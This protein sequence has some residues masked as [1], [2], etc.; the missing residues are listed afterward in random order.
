MAL[1][2]KAN[3]ENII[4]ANYEID[5]KILSPFLPKG[6][7]LDL[8][9]EKCYISLVGFMFKKTKLFT[10][11]I[12]F[13]GN[14]EEIN[15]RFYV[16]RKEENGSTKRGVVFINET[17]PYPIVAWT[18]NK[19]YNENYTVVPTKHKIIEEK[20]VKKV[21]F[22]WLLNKKWNSIAVTTATTSEKMKPNSLESFIYEHYYGYTKTSENETE[23]YK[24]QHPSWKVSEVLDYKIECDF[25]AMYGKSFSVLNQTKP[26]AVFIADGS[27]VGIEWKRNQLDLNNERR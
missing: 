26:E 25:E 17:I 7:E 1:F 21:K 18:A 13:F 24:L 15:L 4:M 8:F 16:K 10:I 23:E 11:P 19:L 14:F 20:L 6:V 3:W 5:P 9:N 22:E 2:L 12:P 27:S